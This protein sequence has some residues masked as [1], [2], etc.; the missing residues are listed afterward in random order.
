MRTEKSSINYHF[1]REG[2]IQAAIIPV[3][4]LIVAIMAFVVP[5]LL[6]HFR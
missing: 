2:V 6:E 4:V 1:W 5:W 3:T